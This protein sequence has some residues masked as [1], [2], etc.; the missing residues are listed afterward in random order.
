MRAS[1]TNDFT[2]PASTLKQASPNSLPYGNS[3]IKP[4]T[5]FSGGM[6]NNASASPGMNK[7]FYGLN[8][9]ASTGQLT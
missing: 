7:S 5:D 8:K 6:N 3:G 2:M 9:D 4:P 1:H